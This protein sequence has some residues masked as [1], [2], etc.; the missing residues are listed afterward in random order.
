MIQTDPTSFFFF[1]GASLFLNPISKEKKEREEIGPIHAHF[2]LIVLLA[3][4]M[5]MRRNSTAMTNSPTTST[6]TE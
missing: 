6:A 1:E 4:Q 3:T 2:A 5:D